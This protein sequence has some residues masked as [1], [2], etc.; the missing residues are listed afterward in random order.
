MQLASE[1]FCV[2]T[3]TISSKFLSLTSKPDIITRGFLLLKGNEEIL[4]EA[5]DLV[6]ESIIAT[7]FKTQDWTAIK[8]NI[9]K[10]LQT[11]FLKKVKRKPLILPVIIETK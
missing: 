8:N 5:K 1:G 9:R 6:L 3:I 2:V 4:E 10:I 11:F 7:N